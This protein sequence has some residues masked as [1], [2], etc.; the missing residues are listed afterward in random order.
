LDTTEG[1]ALDR[2]VGAGLEVGKAQFG[3][4][5]RAFAGV[6]LPGIEGVRKQRPAVVGP[7]CPTLR[8]PDKT[9]AS[10]GRPD[11]VGL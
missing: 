7:Q 2:L 8:M 6:G 9:V 11:A 1:L 10:A 4:E 5:W 3:D